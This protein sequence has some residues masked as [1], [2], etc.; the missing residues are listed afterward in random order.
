MPGG[1]Q[2]DLRVGLQGL[3]AG[4]RIPGFPPGRDP[5]LGPG[6]VGMAQYRGRK[7]GWG[8][9]EPRRAHMD[10][11]ADV[12][13]G[14]PPPQHAPPAPPPLADQRPP[15]EEEVRDLGFRE[16]LVRAGG[17]CPGIRAR[18]A[19]PVPPPADAVLHARPAQLLPSGLQPAAPAG[20]LHAE[21]GGR[22]GLVGRAGGQGPGGWAPFP[23][24][25]SLPAAGPAGDRLGSGE[26]GDGAQACCHP[27]AGEA[28]P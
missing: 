11:T 7:T 20:P 3:G 19:S 2:G 16:C 27:A 12:G 21:A 28:L 18:A 6:R 14:P 9:R 1:S 25:T 24:L 17:H 5:T 4:V 8:L 15:G 13:C 22:G 10:S 26:A 23:S